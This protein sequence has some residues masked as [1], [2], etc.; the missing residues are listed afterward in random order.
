[1]AECEALGKRLRDIEEALESPQIAST[2]KLVLSGLT[3]SP[4]TQVRDLVIADS[5]IDYT[6]NIVETN[7][8][9]EIP[10]GVLGVVISKQSQTECTILIRG[11]VSGFSGLQ[12]GSHLFVSKAGQ[13]TTDVPDTGVVQELA[14]AISS[15][16]ILYDP[17]D[18]RKRRDDTV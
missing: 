11:R 10:H 6:V 5:T 12:M 4:S 8:K 13:F 15:T 7:K 3:C 1:M 9:T 16:E 17:K 2:E 14:V 18:P